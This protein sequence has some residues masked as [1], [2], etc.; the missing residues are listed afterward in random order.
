MKTI[1]DA[2]QLDSVNKL[3]EHKHV[4]VLLPTGYGKTRVGQ[5]A[6]ELIGGEV[7]I[8]SSR[9]NLVEA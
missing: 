4:T 7:L 6:V 2:E 1:R 3:V 9:V 8:V 5:M